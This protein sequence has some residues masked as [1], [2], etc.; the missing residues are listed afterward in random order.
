MINVPLLLKICDVIS[1]HP[2]QFDINE[3]D[4]GTK[5]CIAGWALR[6]SGTRYDGHSVRSEKAREILGLTLKQGREL[7]LPVHYSNHDIKTAEQAVKFIH[8]F[9]DKHEPHW[10]KECT[11]V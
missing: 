4:C 8:E 1:K 7:F 3:W 9:L 6:L 11:T 10:R 2:E 5:A